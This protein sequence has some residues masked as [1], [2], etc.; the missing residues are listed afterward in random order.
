M[1]RS[2]ALSA[3][4][5]EFSN[6]TI[7]NVTRSSMS[8]PK[9]SSKSSFSSMNSSMEGDSM[10]AALQDGGSDSE[11]SSAFVEEM[12]GGSF[13]A[14]GENWQAVQVREFPSLLGDAQTLKSIPAPVNGVRPA[15]VKGAPSPESALAQLLRYRSQLVMAHAVS[16][17]Y[18]PAN[19]FFGGAELQ[20]GGDL[21]MEGGAL[22]QQ[23]SLLNQEADSNYQR[24]YSIYNTI[25]AELK[26]RHGIDFEPNFDQTMVR[27]MNSIREQ[28]RIV[29]D[30][31]VK[32][33]LVQHLAPMLKGDNKKFNG[34]LPQE[35]QNKLNQFFTQDGKLRADSLQMVDMLT[36]LSSGIM[37]L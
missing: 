2:Q 14:A 24:L 7:Q 19:I 35:I 8:S 29:R 1:S 32:M 31:L 33:N 21:Q 10:L 11:T 23:M 6:G 34:Q 36:Q 12:F 20:G 3:V 5:H 9:N 4:Q 27:T 28:E 25:R 17:P 16:I 15:M 26:M 30:Y 18:V 13:N 37:A 22:P